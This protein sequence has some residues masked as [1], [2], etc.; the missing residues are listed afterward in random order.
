MAQGTGQRETIKFWRLA[1][2][3]WKTLILHSSFKKRS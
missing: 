1:L 2:D 3:S